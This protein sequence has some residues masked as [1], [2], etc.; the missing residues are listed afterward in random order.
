MRSVRLAFLA[1]G[2]PAAE[3]ELIRRILQPESASLPHLTIRHSPRDPQQLWE[4]IAWPD[5][6]LS[7][8]LESA[9]TFD[10]ASSQPISTL[11]IGCTSEALELQS[12]KPDFPTSYLHFTLFSGE[13][14]WVASAALQEL[15]QLP[16][17]LEFLCSVEYHSSS[18]AVI[19]SST[20]S[21]YR[22]VQLTKSA[23]LLLDS[24]FRETGVIAAD[25]TKLSDP[26]RVALVRYAAR[27]LHDSAEVVSRHPPMTPIVDTKAAT[28]DMQLAFWSD[29]E[30]NALTGWDVRGSRR[31]HRSRSAIATP[32]ELALDAAKTAKVFL[33]EDYIDFGDPAAGNGVLLAAA[34]QALG[35]DRFNSAR[36]IEKD[37]SS[38]N[39]LRRKWSRAA[40]SVLSADFLTIEPEQRA[41][42]FLLANPPY[43]RSQLIAAD[44]AAVRQGLSSQLNI[45][46]SARIDLYVYF[47]LKAHAWLQ[48]GA[49]A[50]WIIPSEFLVTDYGRALRVYL[51]SEATLL[52]IHTYDSSDPLFDNALTSTTLLIYR[53]HPAVG[54]NIVEISEH[55]TAQKPQSSRLLAIS[56]LRPARRWSLA[57]L[58]AAT[59]SGPT[60]GDLFEVRRGVATGANRLFVLNSQDL[61]R[62]EVDRSWVKPLVPAARAIDHGCIE[63][64]EDGLPLPFEDR[65]LIDSPLTLEEMS[66]ISPLFGAYLRE[67]Q[68]LLQG[69]A[70]VARRPSPWKQESRG[71]APLLF[72]Y[73]A[74]AENRRHRFIRNKSR[75]IHL[76]NYIGLHPRGRSETQ[77]DQ[78]LDTAHE[79]LS[80]LSPEVLS[81]Y[82]RT[83][84]KSLLK[85]EPREIAALPVTFAL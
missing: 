73:M 52:R 67:T 60:I 65:W 75:G 76:N 81:R 44:L 37:E 70:L 41:W 64:T 38:A 3:L 62:F 57:A 32:P 1:E 59:S 24:A 16:W 69:R 21:L 15:S 26:D 35:V 27:R 56:S 7:I 8:T 48:A 42:S 82:G 46:I 14:S 72:V 34:R 58:S 4:E 17:G 36:V 50:A 2:S 55:G 5:R 33:D 10:N 43:R 11:I 54:S 80:A 9:T 51:T 22:G 61:E 74:K 18:R 78:W 39:L 83:Y 19:A 6:S 20:S 29:D 28:G 25:L 84:G 12:Y 71:V 23:R 85:L 49:V 40:A 66:A 79:A 47:I 63:S 68:P 77:E 45:D 53:K 31:R 13:P 30:L